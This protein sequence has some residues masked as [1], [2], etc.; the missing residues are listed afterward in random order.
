MFKVTAYGKA[1]RSQ[2]NLRANPLP[3]ATDLFPW[4]IL[5]STSSSSNVQS[6]EWVKVWFLE[7]IGWRNAVGSL[8]EL[9]WLNKSLS[10][11]SIYWKTR[12]NTGGYG[13]EQY[14]FNSTVS[15][16]I[17]NSQNLKLRVSNP[18]TMSFHFVMPFDGSN[19]IPP[20]SHED[21]SPSAGPRPR[22]P[23][24]YIRI[25]KHHIESIKL[26]TY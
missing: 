7:V 18:R 20:T 24:D 23:R 16:H 22:I 19:G 11:A 6:D 17:F 8:I 5:T 25:L 10:R 2:E 14:H 9:L 3:E 12:D 1:V 15:S 21:R 26:E 4:R 13:F